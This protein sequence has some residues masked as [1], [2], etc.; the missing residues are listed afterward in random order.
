MAKDPRYKSGEHPAPD[1][2]PAEEL[3]QLST[4]GAIGAE[5]RSIRREAKLQFHHLGTRIDDALSALRDVTTAHQG[6]QNEQSANMVRVKGLETR[7]KNLEESSKK[8][9]ENEKS[10]SWKLKLAQNTSIPW[11][12]AAL[13]GLAMVLAAIT[14]RGA[15]SLVPYNKAPTAT[16]TS[17]GIGQ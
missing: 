1:N 8:P 17:T 2:T 5:V 15:S 4:M 11:V 10:S 14:G 16:A 12:L 6:T 7:V 3:E 9:D 13:L